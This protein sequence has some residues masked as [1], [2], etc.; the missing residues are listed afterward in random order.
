MV[1]RAVHDA[2]PTLQQRQQLQVT[3]L[4]EV[5]VR[6][7]KNLHYVDI[8]AQTE[9]PIGPSVLAGNTEAYRGGFGGHPRV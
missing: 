6:K 8:V 5:L 1:L 9:A 3:L 2:N 4:L 7:T